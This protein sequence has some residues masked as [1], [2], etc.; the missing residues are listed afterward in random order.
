MKQKQTHIENRPVIAGG[1]RCR[2]EWIG[3]LGSADVNYYNSEWINSKVLLYN[4]GSYIQYPVI[5][6]SGKE[7][8]KYTY[9]S[10]SLY[11]TAEIQHCKSTMCLLTKPLLT[12]CNSMDYNPP[13]SSL[14]G[15][16]QERILE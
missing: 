7:N 15:I 5:N 9:I 13:G 12:L 8:G 10:E 6:H 2:E 11:C 16:F 14:P 3:S 4:T 1:G